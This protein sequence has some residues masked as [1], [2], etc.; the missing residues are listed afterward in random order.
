MLRLSKSTIYRYASD[1]KVAFPSPVCFSPRKYL[2]DVAEIEH[3]ISTC[4]AV[5][6]CVDVKKVESPLDV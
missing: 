4:K 3:W 6:P 2:W 5:P 1:P